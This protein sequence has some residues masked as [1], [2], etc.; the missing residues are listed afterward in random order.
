MY[1]VGV[2]VA[3]VLLVAGAFITW[4]LGIAL[5]VAGGVVIASVVYSHERGE[6]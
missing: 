1:N 2:A 3:L 6:G 4:D 5:L